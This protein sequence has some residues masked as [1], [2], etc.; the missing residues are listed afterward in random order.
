[1]LSALT[2]STAFLISYIIHHNVHGDT[3]FTGIGWIRPVYFATLISHILISV[4]TL[5]M[6]L[7]TFFFA[8]TKQ[9]AR[10]KRLAR[11]TFPL[12]LY[13]SVTGVAIYFLLKANS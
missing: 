11:F 5:P 3:K 10:H 6:V 13:V 1:M 8:L 2:F 7:T 9:F 4:A 12:W